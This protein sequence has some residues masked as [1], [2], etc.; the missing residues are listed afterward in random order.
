MV[1]VHKDQP[2]TLETSATTPTL[3]RSL[4][5]EFDF[6]REVSH[7]LEMSCIMFEMS[8]VLLRGMHSFYAF[9]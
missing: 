5:W 7:S 8:I 4:P 3:S 1:S 6:S 9:L 2:S